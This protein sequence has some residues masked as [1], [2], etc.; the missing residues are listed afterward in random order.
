MKALPGRNNNSVRD[1]FAC[2][3]AL[4]RL[5]AVFFL[6]FTL[7]RVIFYFVFLP[8]DLPATTGEFLRAFYL[9]A[10]FDLRLCAVLILPAAI[11]GFYAKADPTLN[12]TARNAWSAFYACAAFLL[13]LV[14]ILDFGYYGYLERRVNAT[15]L[16]FGGNLAISFEMINETYHATWVVFALILLAIVFFFAF[17]RFVLYER[18]R[19]AFTQKRR[20]SLGLVALLILIIGIHGALNQ[21]PLRWSDAYFSPHRFI[22][23]LSLNPVL[24]LN[25]TFQFREKPYDIDKA[26][27]HYPL[28]SRYWA[29][30]SP[31]A[32][33]MTFKRPVALTPV[34]APRP[35]NVIYIIMESFAS[36][37]TGTWG[38]KLNA[39][40]YFDQLVKR[41]VLFENFFTPSEATA[42][43]IFTMFTSSPD[44]TMRTT[45][46]RNP[47][48]V[49]QNT[50]LNAFIN[51]DKYY[52]IGGSASW[53][54][55]RGVLKNNAKDLQLYE[56]D[57]L[58]GK[59][60]DVWG[61]SDYDLFKATFK[62]LKAR[63]S[64]KPF[65]AFIQ[66]ASF[67]R[68]FTIPDEKGAFESEHPTKA[69]LAE[70]GFMDE[71]EYNS[72]R[73]SDYSL[74]YFFELIDKD[75]TFENT[76]FVIHGDHGLP[77]YNAAHL[78]AGFKN[79]GLNRFHVPLLVL[80]P[81]ML[82]PA[83]RQ[84]MASEVDVMPTLAGL[85]NHPFEFCSMGRNLFND[86]TGDRH[87]DFSFAYYSSPLEILLYDQEYL[88]K[89]TPGKTEGLYKYRDT[90]F[91][92]DHR[93]LEPEKFHEMSDLLQGHYEMARW[94]N[95]NN[96]PGCVP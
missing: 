22:A 4:W 56:Q 29:V 93:D 85:T 67:H 3:Q 95:Y 12:R 73:F 38:N 57:Q 70:G 81:K 6:T 10:R 7:L 18:P 84:E 5:A 27:S 68:P 48:L 80:A 71:A 50:V 61:L 44:M 17:K 37:K 74:G 94:L 64:S 86:K 2:T 77:H 23:D 26:R 11:I 1:F 14:Y 78:P 52:F 76:I 87:Y 79:Y 75:P 65:F 60:T 47:F 33:A 49:E 31:D 20:I 32:Q 82:E 66:S 34:P 91:K 21:Y 72:F 39:S 36:Y 16:N 53:G 35:P 55:I 88:I 89:G 41:G 43:S 90:D 42:R 30:P 92:K 46:T 45:S 19:L 13:L 96:K 40:P 24:F 83:R 58:E 25:D 59:R 28:M 63:S 9:G 51:Y 54:N 15:V 69:A 62:T 8:P